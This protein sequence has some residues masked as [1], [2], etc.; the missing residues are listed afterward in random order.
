MMFGHVLLQQVPRLTCCSFSLLCRP[1]FIDDDDESLKRLIRKGISPRLPSAYS[2]ELCEVLKAML[3]SNVSIRRLLV[4]CL[5]TIV[6]G[7]IH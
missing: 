2:S 6:K 4:I 1:L 3:S 5:V 7:P